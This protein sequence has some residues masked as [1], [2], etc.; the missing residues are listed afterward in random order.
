[1][2][3]SWHSSYGDTWLPYSVNFAMMQTNKQFNQAGLSRL[4]NRYVKLV[5]HSN[6]SLS[7]FVSACLPK[8]AGMYRQRYCQLV[9]RSQRE[10]LDFVFQ[11]KNNL[12]LPD[13]CMYVCTQSIRTYWG[14]GSSKKI[15]HS[16]FVFEYF[17]IYSPSAAQ[18]AQIHENFSDIFDNLQ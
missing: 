15:H 9:S 8:L 10:P 17:T 2:W 14:V 7:L 13:V 3:H 6:S 1:M 4:E 5:K 12:C 16:V 11:C 18:G